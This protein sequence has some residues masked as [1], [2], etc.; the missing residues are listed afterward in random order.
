VWRVLAANRAERQ[1]AWRAQ[2]W[3]AV[4]PATH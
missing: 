2:H 1:G 3:F 4:V